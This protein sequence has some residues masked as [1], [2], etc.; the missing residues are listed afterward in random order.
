M[1]LKYFNLDKKSEFQYPS[2]A[3]HIV[4]FFN[5]INPIILF[6]DK[7]LTY[8]PYVWTNF[9]KKTNVFTEPVERLHKDG[10]FVSRDSPEALE[11]VIWRGFFKNLHNEN[12]SNIIDSNVK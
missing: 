5:R 3:Y 2:I 8:L 7:I 6:L 10:I 11:E 9:A 4:R 1:D 12:I